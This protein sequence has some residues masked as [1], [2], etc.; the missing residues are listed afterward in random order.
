MTV[1]NAKQLLLLIENQ[2]GWAPANPQKQEYWRLMSTHAGRINKKVTENPQ[3]YS[4][5]NLELAVA[6]LKK[7]RIAVKSPMLVFYVVPSA[8]ELAN[9]SEQPR[10]LADLIDSAIEYEMRHELPGFEKWCER[11]VRAFGEARRE[12]YAQWAKARGI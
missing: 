3:L 4:W 6:F 5:R 9:E 12:V 8:L 7:R 11:L 1:R 10:P 2:L